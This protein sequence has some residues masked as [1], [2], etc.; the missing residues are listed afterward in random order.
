MSVI[1]IKACLFDLDGVIVDTA[2]YHYLAWKR[3]ANQLGF[4]F[5]EHQNEELKGVSRMKSLELILEWGG[6]S[7]P[8]SEK[9][10]WATLKNEWYLELVSEMTPAEVLPGVLD[11][12]AQLKAQNIKIAL[13]SVSK[14]AKLILQKIELLNWFDA[15]I[16]G[17]NLTHGKP[18]PQVFLLG[19]QALNVLPLEC[20]VFEDAV[21]GIES[22]TRAGMKSVGIGSAQVLT[23]ANI[24]LPGFETLQWTALAAMLNKVE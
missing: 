21:A 14:N 22:A 18:D 23:Q 15:I 5:S 1:T 6:V 2:K 9:E 10:R 19:A 11:F 4:D 8:D 3:L 13:G 7:L 12:L 16:D 24:V 20:V 17:T